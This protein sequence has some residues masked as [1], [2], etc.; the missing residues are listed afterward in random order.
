MDF[1]GDGLPDI[2]EKTTSGINVRY[3]KG[4]GNWSYWEPI[5]GISQISFGRSYS[6]S[7]DLSVTLG[8]TFF[9]ILKVCVGVCGSPYNRSFS[10]DSVQIT[11][12]N[13]DGYPDYVTSSDESSM[14][15]RYNLSGKTNLL[16]KVTNF[17][18]SAILLDYEMPLSS[19][20]KPQRCWTLSKVEV[21][22]SDS[23]CPIGGNRSKTT[24][25]YDSPHYDRSERM[26]Y[27][28]GS[29]TTYQWNTDG[30]IDRVYRYTVENY[31]NRHFSRRGKKTRDCIYDAQGNPFIENLYEVTM[32]DFSDG[33]TTDEACP[34]IRYKGRETDICKYY[35]G[36][37]IPHVITAVQRE[38][39]RRRNVTKY[40]N[41]GYSWNNPNG[42]DE[43]FKAD[44]HYKTGM[45][46]N[47]ISLQ[48]SIVIYNHD[49][50]TVLQKRY[51][52]YD[53]CGRLIHITQCNNAG[54]NAEFDIKYDKYGNVSDICYPEN[55]FSQRMQFKYVYDSIVHAFP[56]EVSNS[57]GYQSSSSYDFKFGKPTRTIDI[58]G[59]VMCYQYDD[60]GR[61]VKIN[62]PY[63]QGNNAYTITMEY[64][65]HIANSNTGSKY[66]YAYTFHFDRQHP[67][68]PIR[69]TLICD[70]L[71]R[72][73][74]TKKDAEIGGTEVSLV[75]GKVEYDCFGRVVKQYHPFT[76][77]IDSAKVY[78]D[79][80][81]LY[82]ETVSRYDILDRQTEVIQPLNN[83]TTRYRYWFGNAANGNTCFQTTVTDPNGNSTRTLMGSRQQQL[84]ITAP[85]GI[86]TSFEYSP[87]VQLVRSTD[88]DNLSTTY[89]YDM[90]GR[91]TQRTHPD[92]GTDRY[93]YDPCGN[94]I[95]HVNGNS[96]IV[97]YKYDYN[98]LTDIEY[99]NYPANNVHYEYGGH[100][101]AYNRTGR[102]MFQEDASGWQIFSYGKLGEVTENIRTFA[103]PFE[104]KPFTFKMKYTYDSFNR[105]QQMT[106]PDGEKVNYFYNL[107]DLLR[108]LGIKT[109]LSTRNVNQLLV[110]EYYSAQKAQSELLM[111]SIPIASAI[112]D[113]WKYHNDKF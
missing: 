109:Q 83:Y 4:D 61:L 33:D 7:A 27:G 106:Y 25:E 107:G 57:Y 72:I 64:Y 51:A 85:L 23:L 55:A 6:E 13:G 10:K 47:L 95:K 5:N 73:M 17:T 2:I 22:N 8:M 71:G 1:N 54:S 39:D 49:S 44:I 79:T 113:F 94:M 69:T 19:F 81:T 38:Y 78:N 65:P 45:P 37:S 74:Q 52:A 62:G 29:V 91:M 76:E 92:A 50:S 86:E 41:F 36:D 104:S 59:N 105:I 90:L 12:I 77:D 99:P 87:L 14:T 108:T 46:N 100:G 42:V 16:Q 60:I 15:V 9:S 98:H 48:D 58:N 28:F 112:Q 93:S 40:I 3:N 97:K 96:Q 43:C 63:E 84:K 31:D 88:P 103:L 70:G 11:D 68:N 102:I 35:E 18:G 75:T 110:C 80:I 101:A 21:L 20:E 24:F 82:S 56:V 30:F 53:N 67:S 111:P 26:D 34:S 89:Q 32:I 66:S